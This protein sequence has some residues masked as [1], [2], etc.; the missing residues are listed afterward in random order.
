M[1]KTILTRIMYW[2]IVMKTKNAINQRFLRT[3]AY[4]G[5]ITGTSKVKMKMN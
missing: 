2:D 1:D 3:D 4:S 5:F